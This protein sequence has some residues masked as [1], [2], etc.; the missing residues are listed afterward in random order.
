MTETHFI[1]LDAKPD[2]IIVVW[3]DVDLA[4]EN[5]IS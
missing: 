4:L 3:L 2:V 1:A 5:L